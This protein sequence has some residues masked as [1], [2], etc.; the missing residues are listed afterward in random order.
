MLALQELYR[1]REHAGA[2]S[3]VAQAASA[4]IEKHSAAELQ[5]LIS[6]LDFE[7]PSADCTELSTVM[8]YWSELLS[9]LW[10][11]RS[12]PTHWTARWEGRPLVMAASS[13]AL[14][15]SCQLYT[16]FQ[17]LCSELTGL[18]YPTVRPCQTPSGAAALETEGRWPWAGIPHLRQHAELGVL[19]AILGQLTDSERLKSAAQ[20]LAL[21][22]TQALNAEGLPHIGLFTQELDADYPALLAANAVLF[23]ATACQSQDG[24]L[25]A[26]ADKHTEA[27]ARVTQ[28]SSAPIPAWLAVVSNCWEELSSPTPTLDCSLRELIC[29]PQTALAA[30]RRDELSVAATLCG[31]QSGIGSMEYKDVALLAYGPQQ[32]ALHDC[33]GFGILSPITG[34]PGHRP[35][36][37]EAGEQGFALHGRVS[38]APQEHAN[39]SMASYGVGQPAGVWLDLRQEFR[40]EQLVIRAH[41]HSLRPLNEL[42]FS[43]LAKGMRCTVD[44]EQ[45]LEPRSLDRYRGK[46]RSV[47]LEGAEGTLAIHALPACGEL[48]VIPLAG[49][50]NFWGA[51]FLIAQRLDPS[52]NSYVWQVSPEA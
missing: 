46:V 36:T 30:Y 1:K 5:E 8:E 7:A 11:S 25:I 27:L 28:H 15:R 4:F 29:D 19:W 10:I 26:L 16:A 9:L 34:I 33:H 44:Q 18:P 31:G 48:E 49:G 39:A 22:Q 47:R 45:V 32:H 51:D 12:K 35:S 52:S 43:F 50:A 37:V 20:R 2:K 24:A 21:W 23:H 42:A 13:Q 6:Q 41:Y 14:W 17:A 3:P 38:L 40:K